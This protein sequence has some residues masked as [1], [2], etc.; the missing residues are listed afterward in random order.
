MHGN[1]N[2]AQ[3]EGKIMQKMV[4]DPKP[5]KERYA[6]VKTQFHT[7][8]EENKGSQILEDAPYIVPE[9]SNC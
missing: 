5:L 7:I 4:K 1:E 9:Q 8:K 6:E 2:Y 3:A